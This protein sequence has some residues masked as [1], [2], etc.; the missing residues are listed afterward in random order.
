MR[1]RQ[2]GNT[3]VIS[4]ILLLLFTIIGLSSVR[5]V[6]MNQKVS[7]NYRESDFTF[8]AAEAALAEGEAYARAL[9]ANL[10]ESDFAPSCT[11]NYCFTSNCLQG[12]CFNGSYS[13]GTV[14]QISEPT[15]RVAETL[16]MWQAGGN[17]IEST[18]SF[19]ELSERPRFLIE[20]MCY[21]QADPSVSGLPVPPPY[22]AVD[23][24]YL[25]R[26]TSHAQSLNGKSRV[27]LQSTYKVLR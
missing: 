9:S 19:P 20:F 21:V 15:P 1:S 4:L 24:A 8:H 10:S 3:I 5:N 17:S 7:T 25:F 16:S 11:G 2:S 27:I 6:G 14:C 22:P 23:W 12:R 18:I 13:P 26:I